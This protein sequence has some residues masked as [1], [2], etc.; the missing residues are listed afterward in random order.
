MKKFWFNILVSTFLILAFAPAKAWSQFFFFENSLI[1]KQAPDFTLKTT[2]GNEGS[3]TQFRGEENAILFF[4]ATWC[5]HCRA[6]LDQL[7]TQKAVIEA[8]GI[9]LALIDIGESVEVVNKY[10]EKNNVQFEG[11]LDQEQTVAE[12]YGLVGVPTFVFISKEGLVKS[13]Q[14]ALPEDLDKVFK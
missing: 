5:P 3:L 10:F 9:K 7:K 6:Q 14:H 13:V 12:Q 2:A 4:W 11:F 1:G 8:Q